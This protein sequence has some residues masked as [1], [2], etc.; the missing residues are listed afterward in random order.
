MFPPVSLIPWEISLY[1]S[2]EISVRRDLALPLLWA[3]KNLGVY[4]GALYENIVG[5]AL[6]KSGCGLYYYK[7]EIL[8]AFHSGGAAIFRALQI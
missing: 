4:K 1:F 3:N 2:L 8:C 6:V 7:R 5:E